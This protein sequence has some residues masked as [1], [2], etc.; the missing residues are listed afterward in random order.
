MRDRR[1]LYQAEQET[2]NA[3]PSLF[4]GAYACPPS[5]LFCKFESSLFRLSANIFSIFFSCLLAASLSSLVDP[6][7]PFLFVLDSSLLGIWYTSE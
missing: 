2:S 7:S 3:L 6:T 1:T 4:L 5:H